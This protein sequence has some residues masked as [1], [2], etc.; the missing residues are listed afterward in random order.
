MYIR[1]TQV[2]PYWI[3]LGVIITGMLVGLGLAGWWWLSGRGGS[4]TQLNLLQQWVQHP[5][6]HP[7]WQVEAGA[8]CPNAPMRF[9]TTGYIGF[10]WGDSFRPG[11]RHSGFDIFSP[12]GEQNVTPIYAAYS[13]YLTREPSWL[14]TVILRHPDFAEL[15]DLV[16][17]KQIW[18]YY[19][20]MASIDGK[21]S[22]VERRFPPGTYGV[23][24]EP[25]TLLGYQGQ[26]SGDAAAPTGLHLHISIVKSTADGSYANETILEN[27][28]D[29]APFFGV[30]KNA[31]GIWVCAA[32]E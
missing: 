26:W 3:L 1:T 19:T 6:G 31:A 20:H 4:S 23:Y 17:G 32:P 18:T 10:G 2:Q 21:T 30:Q 13:G 24:V 11:H 16:G 14:S 8:S 27:T 22:F 12:D 25:G 28:Y 9:P 15:P 5:A 29:P 7:E